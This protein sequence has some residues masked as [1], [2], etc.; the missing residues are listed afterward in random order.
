MVTVFLLFNYI[1]LGGDSGAQCLSR[2]AA[3][4]NPSIYPAWRGF[5]SLVFIPLGGCTKGLFADAEGGENMAKQVIAAGR[6]GDT[7]EGVV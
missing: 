3:V 5:R 1:L 7:A 2:L 4:R 6:A